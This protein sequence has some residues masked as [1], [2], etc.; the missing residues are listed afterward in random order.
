MPN[1][2]EYQ[3]SLF[4]FFTMKV[5]ASDIKAENIEMNASELDIDFLTAYAQANAR[6]VAGIEEDEGFFAFL[7]TLFK[8]QNNFGSL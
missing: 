1:K 7:E 4:G 8:S 2:L 6:K 5:T 3:F